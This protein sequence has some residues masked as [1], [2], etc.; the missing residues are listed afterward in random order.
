MLTDS[1]EAQVR[2]LLGRLKTDGWT[3]TPIRGGLPLVPVKTELPTA[4]EDNRGRLI[5]I[6]G[7]VGVA[8]GIYACVKDA[9]DAY[10]WTLLPNIPT[11]SI[12]AL[13]DA[14]A[15]AKPEWWNPLIAQFA[16]AGYATIG[17]SNNARFWPMEPLQADVTVTQLLT[18]IGA[19][20]GNIDAGIYS[21]DGST[22]TRVV[23]LGST[24]CPAVSTRVV[25]NIADTALTRG[26]RYFNAIAIDNNTASYPRIDI[27][28][29]S[30]VQ[31]NGGG[32]LKASS[33]PLPSTVTSLTADQ[34]GAYMFGVL[35]GGSAL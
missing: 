18:G 7:D 31:P 26:V 33:F 30:V 2:D 9:A 29:S 27:T 24:A 12:Q 21:W 14:T 35:S 28:G 13:I 5:A 17:S 16:T 6:Q 11:A 8:D 23:S 20:S 15:L 34:T 19:Q 32:Y 3:G 4:S 22:M 25:L 10:A 1:E